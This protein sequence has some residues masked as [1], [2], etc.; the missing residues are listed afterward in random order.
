MLAKEKMLFL[1]FYTFSDNFKAKVMRHG[2]NCF[3]DGRII[4]V[5]DESLV[6]RYIDLSTESSWVMTRRLASQAGLLVGF[7]SGAAV[8]GAICVA[9]D[10]ESG[11]VVTVLPD[12]GSKYLSLGIFD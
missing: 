11:V 12:D 9:R 6:D 3:D 2:N 7:S 5:F 8:E 10:I 1:R 4:A